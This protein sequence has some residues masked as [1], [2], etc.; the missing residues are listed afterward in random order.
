MAQINRLSDLKVKGKLAPGWH[1]DG[2]NLFLRVRE[3]GSRSWFFRYKIAGKVK[4]IG[5]GTP[6]TRKLK[7]LRELASKMRNAVANGED[8]AEVLKAPE[9]PG[10]KTFK[11]YAEE[12]IAAKK[13]GWRNAKHIQQW[14]N[15]LK[16][17]AYPVIGDRLAA[18]ITLADVKAIL[19]P[20]WAT[21]TETASRLRMRLEAVLD[22]AAVHEGS[23]RRN[24]ARWRG[25]LDKLFA[26]PRKVSPVRHHDAAPYEKV[27]ALM[28][29]LQAKDSTSALC[30]RFTILTAA[31]SGE[32][33]GARW[34]EFDEKAKVWVI[35]AERMKAGREHKVPLSDDALAI[36][37]TMKP[38][39]VE[40]SD[41][42]FPGPT[43]GQLSDVAI[44]KTLH[45]IL[46]DV[47]VHGFRSSFRQWGA[48]TTSYP[49]AALEL[50]LAHVNKDKVEAAYQRSDLYEK[51]KNLMATWAKFCAKVPALSLVEGG[52]E[53][54]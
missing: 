25:N 19:E 53:A 33:R 13:A 32:A 43:G 18:D 1:A 22:Y 45:A 11:A 38:R 30:L 49:S 12:L 6:Q 36:L 47:T 15:T 41:I 3:T 23:D 5:L 2:G 21:R 9:Q 34:S 20:L 8:P 31:R 39:R 40:G 51:R 46:P 48:E 35:P 42:V 10:A 44:N 16:A 24:P 29:S 17:Y 28:A 52:I 7:D 37:T 14:G 54:A 27:P 50:A 26:A 4:E